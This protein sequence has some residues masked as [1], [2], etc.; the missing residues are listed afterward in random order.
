MV[1]KGH[2]CLRKNKSSEIPRTLQTGIYMQF[3]GNSK[4]FC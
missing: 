4:T 1:A 3:N 2:F